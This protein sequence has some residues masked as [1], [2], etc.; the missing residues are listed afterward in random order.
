[1]SALRP[2]KDAADR[3]FIKET[4]LAAWRRQGRGPRYIKIGRS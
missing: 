2:G 3:L 4:T 1:M